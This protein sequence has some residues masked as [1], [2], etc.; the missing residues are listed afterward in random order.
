MVPAT[1]PAVTERHALIVA[2]GWDGHQ[3]EASAALLAGL[4]AEEGFTPTVA[5]TL[6]VL[7]DAELLR[8][9]ALLV[10]NWTMDDLPSEHEQTLVQAVRDGVGLGGVH[11]GMGDS[12][13]KAEH[14]QWVVG[15]QFV[16]HPD[17]VVDYHVDLVPDHP[18]TV[19]LQGFDVHSE[20]YYMHVDP[21]NEV[22]ATTT[23]HR[24]H[25]P[26]VDGVVM[27]V[28]WRRRFGAGRVF[29][30][31][32]GHTPQDLEPEP[33]RTLLRRGLRWAG[34]LSPT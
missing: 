20:Q 10:P 31:S 23:F 6:D 11:G 29:Y 30:L 28:A 13:R 33:V 25:L 5:T 18:L 4:L 16:G 14:Y 34:G 24:P 15:G 27:P 19:G 32:V 21:S 22:V 9:Q 12:F 1:V 17:G 2:G 8:R 7:A 3:P 26:W